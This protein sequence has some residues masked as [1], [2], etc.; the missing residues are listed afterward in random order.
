MKKTAP[1]AFMTATEAAN[2]IGVSNSSV[3]R[4]CNDQL[5]PTHRENGRRYHQIAV[6]DVQKLKVDMQ[7]TGARTERHQIELVMKQRKMERERMLHPET[8]PATTG[9]GQLPT[10]VGGL[11]D[12]TSNTE[13]RVLRALEDMAASLRQLVLITQ[14]V[15]EPTHI[16][17]IPSKAAF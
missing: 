16:E 2:L 15:W 14:R 5:I 8:A 6:A 12:S 9:A 13:E 7:A 10:Q 4:M 11:I 17:M 1:K 3:N